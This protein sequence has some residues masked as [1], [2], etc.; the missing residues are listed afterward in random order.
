[1]VERWTSRG[2]W[3][4]SR[5]DESYP[6]RLKSYLGQAAPPLLFG[7]GESRLLQEGGLAIV[8]S[9][10]ASEEDI[11]F[12]R[13][14]AAACVS[15]DLAVIS[16][17]ARGVDLEAMAAAFEAG[18]KALG[19]IPDGL[20][21]IAVSARYREALVSGRL[22][23]ISPYDPDARWFA[24]TAMERNKLIYALSDAALVVS[25]A[26]ESGG[27]WTGAIEALEAARI[28]VY[29]KAQGAVKDGNRKLL[30]R[31]SRPFPEE[32][33]TDIRSLFTALAPEPTLFTPAP[34]SE[35][36]LPAPPASGNSCLLQETE[37]AADTIPEARPSDAFHRILP[38]MLL[39][40]AEPGT[41]KNVE[42]A[43]GVVPA[44]AK[45][46]I[47]RACDEGHVR[48][49]T[50]P[51]RYVAAKHIPSLFGGEELGA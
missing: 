21:R 28:P 46:W 18:G 6:G 26:V 17:G 50:R 32:P 5:S 51:V 8:G 45:A 39:A 24:F 13:T 38:D 22:V 7:A 35:P 12:A 27:T 16:G 2:L 20:A 40:L 31:G 3:V 9:R 1:M 49:L 25:S 44:Q 29:V 19:V 42:Q 48:K 23:L 36:P 33:W 41:E 43:L 34:A 14:V 47:K 4:L 11:D 15:Q 37:A 10:D 30:A